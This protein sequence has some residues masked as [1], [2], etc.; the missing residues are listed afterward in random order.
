MRDSGDGTDFVNKV[1]KQNVV[2]TITVNNTK[3]GNLKF[4]PISTVIFQ[5]N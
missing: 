2:N 1:K 4:F 5:E 3:E